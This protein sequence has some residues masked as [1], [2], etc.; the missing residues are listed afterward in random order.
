MILNKN[1]EPHVFSDSLITTSKQLN[2]GFPKANLDFKAG[3]ALS[4]H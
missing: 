3:F 1:K 2:E 4:L